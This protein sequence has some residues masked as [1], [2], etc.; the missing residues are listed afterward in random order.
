M[1][2]GFKPPPSFDQTAGLP[3]LLRFMTEDRRREVLIDTPSQRRELRPTARA[4]RKAQKKIYGSITADPFEAGSLRKALAEFRS[5][6]DETQVKSH[7]AFEK[8]IARLTP[9][10]R[11]LLGQAMRSQRKHRPNSPHRPNRPRRPPPPQ[12][13]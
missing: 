2:G 9:E 11:R 13:Q 4:L 1:S 7:K 5:T 3:R 8:A 6:L 12:R 10:E